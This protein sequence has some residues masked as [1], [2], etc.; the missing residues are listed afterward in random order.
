MV[1]SRLSAARRP[2]PVPAAAGR[3]P[4]PVS[5][6]VRLLVGLTVLT[7]LLAGPGLP[8][9]SAPA[10][11]LTV[12][13]PTVTSQATAR[14]PVPPDADQLERHLASYLR[15]R[16][17]TASVRVQDLRTGAVYGY[18]SSSH[19]DSASVVK[20][21]IMAAVLRRQAAQQRYLTAREVRLLK[22]MIRNSDND[23]ASALYASLGRGPALAGFFRAAGM[24]HTTPGP[25]RYWGLTQITAADQVVLLRHL[26]RPSAL[27]TER[28]RA[29][30]RDLMATVRSSQDWG[31]SA[32]PQAAG[33]RI[34]LKNGWL[35]R[36]QRGWRVHSIGHVRGAGRDYLVAVLTMDNKTMD[37]GIGVVEGVSRIIW[38]DLAPAG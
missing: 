37:R 30:A 5:V 28:G 15:A 1:L 23:A 33:A 38:R 24:T 10:T 16:S 26:A 34:E 4:G 29:F 22:A 6:A 31:V 14:A 12:T 9:W 2:R 11:A 13:A 32:G 19:Y 20:V 3:R 27:L 25:G 17:V 8:A 36:S 18:R 7:G 35:S 21:A